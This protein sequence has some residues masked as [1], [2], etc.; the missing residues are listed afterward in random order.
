M[1]IKK[2]LISQPKP[3]TEKSPYADLTE[4]YNVKVDFQPFIKVEG[5][6]AKEFRQQRIDILSHTA[7]VFTARTAIDHFFRICEELRITIPE[8]MKYF[9]M[10]EAIA[11]YL[12]KYIVYR[13]RKI[14]FGNGTIDGLLAI[15]GTKHKSETFLIALSDVHKNDIPKAFTKAKIS[16]TAGI[17]YKTVYSDMK[18]YPITDYDLL[19]F[20]SP[21]EIKSLKENFPKFEQNGTI[22]ATFGPATAK[23][24]AAEKM[25]ANI[26][27]PTP[28][29][30]SIKMALEN[31]LKSPSKKA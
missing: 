22:I 27:A 9:C 28:E 13:K 23:A 14:F 11:L 10:T 7:V 20:Y 17:F 6:S 18:D 15:I 12:Q 24:V 29:A 25:T 19:V 1:K 8:T 5:V 21:A 3:A 26:Q 2:I 31:Y 4:K 16:Y 30:P